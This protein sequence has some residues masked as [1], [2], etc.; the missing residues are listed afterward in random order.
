M[1]ELM[2]ELSAVNGVS[3]NEDKVRKL[4][5]EKISDKADEITVDALGNV[6]ALKKGR[7]SGKKIMFITNMD[8]TGFIVSEITDKGYLK[9]KSVGKT[10][11]RVIISKK[12]VIGDG[13]KGI[14][15]MKAIHLQKKSERESTVDVEDLFV[16]I[17]ASS[18]KDA[19]KRVSLGDYIAFDS[20]FY[21][22]GKRIR[23]KALD[24]MGCACLINAMD[25]ECEYDTYFVFSA[26]RETGARGA[27]AAAHRI[28]P[29]L[30][31]VVTTEE[32][33]DMYGVSGEEKAAALGGGV[34]IDTADKYSVKNAEL[35]SC[36]RKAAENTGGYQS[37][38]K[39]RGINLANAV[40]TAAEGCAAVSISI[41][42]RYSHTPMCM[43][44][45][46]DIEEASALTARIL[47]E[48]GEWNY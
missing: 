48:L 35:V 29:D 18:K 16:D 14:I 1:A 3:G 12:V 19:E 34:I 22:I 45:K 2:R 8:E 33:A 37:G 24:R 23:G 43:M 27:A 17:G 36:V 38:G 46:R 31:V 47:E 41:P 6:I 39:N 4:I 21:D 11:D 15:G 44:D 9:I 13:E 42:C 32:S 28:R 26:Q 30:T 7:Q 25:T 20:E 40:Q 5:T 10:D